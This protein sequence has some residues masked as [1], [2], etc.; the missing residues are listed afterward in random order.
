MTA[1]APKTHHRPQR[2]STPASAESSSTAAGS[3]DMPQTCHESDVIRQVLLP[4]GGRRPSRN[5]AARLLP[6]LVAD[7]QSLA[8]A[9]PG[10]SAS[11]VVVL[12]RA[13]GPPVTPHEVAQVAGDHDRILSVLTYCLPVERSN[14]RPSTLNASRTLPPRPPNVAYPDVVRTMPSATAGP[15]TSIAPPRDLTLFTVSNS[16]AVSNVHTIVPLSVE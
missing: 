8:G 4:V 15:P 16:R 12:R 13:G 9:E 5:L 1:C 7:S 10:D 6:Q 14:Q 3:T 11:P 2:S